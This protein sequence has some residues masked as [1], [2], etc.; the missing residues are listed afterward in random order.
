MIAF[1]DDH[2]TLY[3][4]EMASHKHLE[5]QCVDQH[6]PS[7]RIERF[8]T[9]EIPDRPVGLLLHEVVDGGGRLLAVGEVQ[10]RF[11]GRAGRIARYSSTS[12]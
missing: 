12:F 1:L 11:C 2:W 6:Q 9:N 7:V 8:R 10:L 5:V 4:V 3:F